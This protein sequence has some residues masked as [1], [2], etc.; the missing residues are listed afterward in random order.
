MLANEKARVGTSALDHRIPTIS[1]L[2]ENV[3]YGLLMSYGQDTPEVFRMLAS[4]AAKIL[5]GAKPAD[6]P[7]E[8][9]TRLKLALNLKAAKVLGLKIPSSLIVVAGEVIE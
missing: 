6:L 4:Y 9:P 3:P 8:Q 7:V 5:K 1:G 2:A